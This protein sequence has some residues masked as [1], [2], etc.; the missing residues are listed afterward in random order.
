MPDADT[1][2]I[3]TLAR[4]TRIDPGG[5]GPDTLIAEELGIDSLLTIEIIANVESHFGIELDEGLLIGISTVGDFVAI[6]RAQVDAQSGRGKG[7]ATD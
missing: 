7:A 3:E 1:T 4:I 5:I 6:I 2:I